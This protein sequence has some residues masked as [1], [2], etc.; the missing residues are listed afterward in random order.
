[1]KRTYNDGYWTAVLLR[2]LYRTPSSRKRLKLV[3]IE[4]YTFAR[5]TVGARLSEAWSIRAFVSTGG[6][7]TPFWNY[8]H[9]YQSNWTD[10]RMSAGFDPHCSLFEPVSMQ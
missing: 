5:K 6:S 2:A 10:V 7:Y 1:M 3:A 8:C 9:S 4:N